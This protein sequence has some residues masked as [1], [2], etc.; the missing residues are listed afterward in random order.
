MFL[1]I[2]FSPSFSGAKSEV[3]SGEDLAQK[4]PYIK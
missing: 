1:S 3:F 2:S 4:Y